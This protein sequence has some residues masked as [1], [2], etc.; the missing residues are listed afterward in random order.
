MDLFA[1]VD[2]GELEDVVSSNFPRDPALFDAAEIPSWDGDDYS[3][4]TRTSLEPNQ[5]A[6]SATG[7]VNLDHSMTFNLDSTNAWGAPKPPPD[8]DMMDIDDIV[9]LR[10]PQPARPQPLRISAPTARPAR[11]PPT[12]EMWDEHKARIKRLYLD[13][14]TPLPQLMELMKKDFD[15]HAT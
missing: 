8:D 13:E 14:D 4:I 2:W 5:S 15:F 9:P 12:S 10:Q 7:M 3:A 6:N 1:N 11:G